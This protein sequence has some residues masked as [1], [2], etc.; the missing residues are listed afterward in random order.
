MDEGRWPRKIKAANVEGRQGRGRPRFVWFNEM[1]RALAVT[2]IDL[3]EATQ[4]ARERK[5]WRELVRACLY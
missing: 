5:V 1:K 2:E 4:L 3:Q